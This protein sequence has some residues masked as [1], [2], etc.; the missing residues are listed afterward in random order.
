MLTI[1]TQLTRVYFDEALKEAAQSRADRKAHNGNSGRSNL[2]GLLFLLV[3][4]V[5]PV[6]FW[7]FQSFMAG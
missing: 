1:N 3:V 4:V 7:L 2:N 5:A 6:V